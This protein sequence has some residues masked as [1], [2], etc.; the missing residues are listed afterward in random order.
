MTRYGVC[1]PMQVDDIKKKCIETNLR[2]YGFPSHNQ[3]D[4]VKQKKAMTFMKHY[5]VT[6]IFALQDFKHRMEITNLFRY[7]CYNPA[8]CDEIKKKI[9]ETNLRRYNKEYYSQTDEFKSRF[10]STCME[11]YGTDH[12]NKSLF[13]NHRSHIYFD[14]YYFDSKAELDFYKKCL[15]EG[16]KI[17]VHPLRLEYEYKNHIHY[18]YPDFEVDGVLIEIKGIHFYDRDN[19]T[20]TNPFNE[21]DIERQQA[22][23]ECAK[24]NNVKIIYV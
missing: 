19:D 14:G 6:N 4:I 7:G 5:G 9:R 12:F 17:I 20:W 11:R 3:S 21:K 16:K 8:Q 13:F 23:C 1:N 10:K 24:R 2:K 15:F 22:R 18:Y